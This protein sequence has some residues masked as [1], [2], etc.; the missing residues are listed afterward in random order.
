MVRVIPL[1]IHKIAREEPITVFGGT[2]KVLDFTY[3]DDC[4]EGIA[5]GIDAW[6]RGACRTRRSTW[7]MG[8]ATPSSA[9]PN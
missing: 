5:A 2:D 8:R 6:P 3:V 7:P 4:V 1:F 9:W